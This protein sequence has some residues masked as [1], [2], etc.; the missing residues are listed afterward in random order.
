MKKI[1]V[2]NVTPLS[3]FKVTIY[4][5]IIP[6]AC[7]MLVGILFTIIASAIGQRG[8][9]AVGIP[10]I[11]LPIIL[12]WVYGLFAMLIALV[13]N[14]LAKKFGGLVLTVKDVENTQPQ[15]YYTNNYNNDY[16]NQ[17]HPNNQDHQ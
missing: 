5:S 9:L 4:Y 16:N 10:Y 15:M 6:L 7:M 11:I 17:N 13:Y 12:I 3:A 1:E 2:T 14:G 8:L